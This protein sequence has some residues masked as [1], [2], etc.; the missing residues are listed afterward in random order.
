MRLDQ[1]KAL[2]QPKVW[3]RPKNSQILLMDGDGACYQAAFSV[4]TLPT[5]IKRVQ[6]DVLTKMFM[7][8]CG[9]ARVHLTAK[10]NRKAERG[11]V[12]AAKPYQGSRKG[13]PKPPL[14]EPLREALAASGGLPEVSFILQTEV[15]ADDAIIMDSYTFKH[16]GVVVSPDKD[17][18]QTIHPWY[19]IGTGLVDEGASPGWLGLVDME[20]TGTQKLVGR[21]MEFFWAQM[22]MGDTADNVAGLTRYEGKTIGPMKTHDLLNGLSERDCATL[23]LEAYAKNNQNAIAEAWLLYL[24]RSPEDNVMRYLESLKLPKSVRNQIEEWSAEDWFDD[25]YEEEEYEDS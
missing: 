18:R 1:I 6:Q 22:L 13:K 10:G 3:S 12:R 14:L 11:R 21:G 20:R 16:N 19:D 24:L 2:K 5:A 23:V 8:G 4:K 15:E 9:R 7:A 17:L 25:N